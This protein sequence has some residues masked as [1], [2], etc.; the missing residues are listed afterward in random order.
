MN[1]AQVVQPGPTTGCM[2]SGDSLGLPGPGSPGVC[3]AQSLR[4]KKTS[5]LRVQVSWREGQP[6]DGVAG[7]PQAA[8]LHGTSA[9]SLIHI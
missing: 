7:A 8:P 3:S 6:W 4:D 9:L 2:A 5:L 1:C